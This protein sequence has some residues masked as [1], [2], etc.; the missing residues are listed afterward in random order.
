MVDP[1]ADED[2]R[3]QA[4]KEALIRSLQHDQ[5]VLE[6]EAP[7]ARMG[8]MSA[9]VLTTIASILPIKLRVA[10]GFGVNFL[11]NRLN[12]TMRF[13]LGYFSMAVTA[14]VITLVYFLILGPTALLARLTGRDYLRL[15]PAEGT[16]WT[17]KEPP[18]DSEERFLRPY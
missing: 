11:F 16:M 8:M 4:D 5:I 6:G 7:K 13:F 12:A 10:F 15:R 17:D 3:R 9:L 1:Q 14:V 18:D 2:A